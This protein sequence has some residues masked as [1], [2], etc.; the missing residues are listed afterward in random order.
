MTEKHDVPVKAQRPQREA[1]NNNFLDKLFS[2]FST[3]P[4]LKVRETRNSPKQHCQQTE[5]A[6][7]LIYQV[8]IIIRKDR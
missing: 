7:Q 2:L 4:V 5:L 1:E 3:V 8:F 6:E